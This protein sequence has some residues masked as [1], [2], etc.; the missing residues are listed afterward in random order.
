MASPIYV[1]GHVNPDTD[2]IAAAMG[3]AWLLR[4]RDGA[5]TVAARA[6]AYNPQTVWVLKYL[7]LEGPALLTDASPR[8]ESVMRR[9]DTVTP[10]RPLHEA[11]T[12]LNRTGGLAPVLNEDGT[13]YGLVTGRSLFNLLS[14]MVGPRI[15]Q[16]ELKVNDFLNLPCKEAAD[17]NV[18]RFQASTRIRD[19]L[20]RILREEGDEFWVLDDNKRYAGICRQRDLLNP[21][22][23]RIIMVD[24]NEPGQAV[25]SLEEAEL[26]EI[27]DHHR[28]GNPSTHTPIKFTV[29]VVGSTS[30][31][32][33]EQT[34]EAGLSAPPPIAGMLLAGLLSD[35]L[36][37]TSPTTTD[38]DRQAAERLGRWAFAAG[39]K[40]AG[41]TIKSYGEKVVAAGA[42]LAAR[43]P[44]EIVSTDMKVY[45]GGGLQFSISQAEVSDLYEVTEHLDK[46]NQALH[47]LRVSRGL[48]FSMLM[49]TDVVRGSSRLLISN[50]PAVLDDLPY[51]PGND[52]TRQAEGVV[53]RKKQLLPVVLGLLE[54]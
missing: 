13:P 34:E 21:P 8:F 5:D 14:R 32:V 25:G 50:S 10:E 20:H 47:D 9:F 41:E 18:A 33:S 17:T 22:R 49:V 16:Q 52:G 1:I 27:L 43:A 42:G 3:Y 38:R 53:S 31:L 39:S 36:I 44:R 37:L 54:E 23:L 51:P 7:G 2:S 29:D 11:W 19:V 4:E 12:I 40:L 35:T 28:L 26:L 45:N 48:D 46:L 6:G 15:K 24:H 30:T